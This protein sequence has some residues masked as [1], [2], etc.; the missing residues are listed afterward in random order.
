MIVLT[1]EGNASARP[2]N[3]IGLL[4]DAV[5]IILIAVIYYRRG[6]SVINA[7]YSGVLHG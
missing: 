7:G 5:M 4:S 1:F 2:L 3:G 6:L